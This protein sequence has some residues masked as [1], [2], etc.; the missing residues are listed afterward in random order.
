MFN[1]GMPI[2]DGLEYLASKTFAPVKALK[3][4]L[5]IFVETALNLCDEYEAAIAGLVD[6]GKL[7][8]S[9]GTAAHLMR[10]AADGQ[11]LR[12]HPI[13]F[14]YTPTPAEPRLPAI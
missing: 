6:A 9:S 12:W 4:D 5:G 2:A 11:I 1:H 8:W 14:S 7:K 10:K 13:E 3:D